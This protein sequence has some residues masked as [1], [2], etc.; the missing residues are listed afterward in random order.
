MD[1][2][3]SSLGGGIEPSEHFIGDAEGDVDSGGGERPDNERVG[4]GELYPG[5]LVEI[6]E[7]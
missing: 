5:E 1:P 4:V 6:Q 2:T 7:V 3:P